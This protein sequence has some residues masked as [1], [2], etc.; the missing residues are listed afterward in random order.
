MKKH[1][2]K[3]LL[4]GIILTFLFNTNIIAEDKFDD[5]QVLRNILQ[6][7]HGDE[8]EE[9]TSFNGEIIDEFLGRE[10]MLKLAYNIK[11]QIAL[12]GE[13]IDPYIENHNLPE[14]FFIKEEIFEKN[15]GQVSYSGFDKD[16][17]YLEIFLTSY[18]DEEMDIEETYLYI[19]CV[20]TEEFSKKND[21]LDKIKGIFNEF[22][23]NV[24]ITT[25]I[26]GAFSGDL[27]YNN[28]EEKIKSISEE[29][30]IET[31]EY[32]LDD[33]LYSYTM[34]TPLIEKFLLIDKKKIN[35]N[36]AIRYNVYEDKT[37]IMIGTPIIA[38]G[39]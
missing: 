23:P 34:Y 27:G 38:N 11:D 5:G 29:Y 26:T 19:N 2:V 22:T 12:V 32:F 37:Y 9:D 10:D 15:Y 36:L 13:E 6:D 3:L 30:K 20:K 18:L 4:T 14:E 17:N 21:S 16:K 8:I 25:C 39:Y 7:F 24:E 31:L 35:L 28:V 33:N 1:I